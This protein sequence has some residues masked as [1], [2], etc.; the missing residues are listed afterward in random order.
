MFIAGCAAGMAWMTACI[1]AASFAKNDIFLIVMRRSLLIP[2]RLRDLID[3]IRRCVG[4]FQ[5]LGAAAT[6][7]SA[8]RKGER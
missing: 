1:L 6:V 3:N 7:P 4:A 5:G 8:V 2:V